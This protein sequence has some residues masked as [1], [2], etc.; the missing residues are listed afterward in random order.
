MSAI[1]SPEAPPTSARGDALTQWQSAGLS[2]QVKADGRRR[3]IAAVHHAML[4]RG[5]VAL[6]LPVGLFFLA[7]VARG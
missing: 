2:L 7:F 3:I 6:L 1:F 5:L 4:R